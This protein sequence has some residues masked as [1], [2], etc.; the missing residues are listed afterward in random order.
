MRHAIQQEPEERQAEEK[1]DMSSSSAEQSLWHIPGDPAHAGG[2]P[3]PRSGSG[4]VQTLQT[5]LALQEA[6]LRQLLAA[7]P[8]GR[9]SDEVAFEASRIQEGLEGIR[10]VIR[11]LQESVGEERAPQHLPSESE[12]GFVEDAY[13]DARHAKTSSPP[14]LRRSF[15][16][17][18]GAQAVR[19]S[20]VAS[21]DGFD[22]IARLEATSDLLT[23]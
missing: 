13:V 1:L 8:G 19:C 15:R 6:E 4:M 21:A 9:L 14:G 17:G 18:S 2:M 10:S 3:P 16:I 20:Q 22:E 12:Q 23:R 5:E 11:T 7:Q